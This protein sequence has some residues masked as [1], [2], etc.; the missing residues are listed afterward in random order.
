MGKSVFARLFHHTSFRPIIFMLPFRAHE[1]VHDILEYG[2]VEE[3]VF[4]LDETDFAAPV[5][6]VNITESTA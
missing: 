6:G 2:C 1:S 4:L 5:F 3:H